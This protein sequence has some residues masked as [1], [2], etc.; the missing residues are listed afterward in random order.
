MLVASL[1]VIQFLNN[2]YSKGSGGL[3]P[4][5]MMRV[6]GQIDEASAMLGLHYRIPCDASGRP[7]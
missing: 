5:D 2:P 4:T 3:R 1:L 6:L 7:L